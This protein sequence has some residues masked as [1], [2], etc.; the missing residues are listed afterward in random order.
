V[1]DKA[2]SKTTKVSTPTFRDQAEKQHDENFWR[3]A[4]TDR[5]HRKQK[6]WSTTSCWWLSECRRTWRQGLSEWST[7]RLEELN[8]EREREGKKEVKD[9]PP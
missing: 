9:Q 1:Q 3:R 8:W 6:T 5:T 7:G 4:T 2:V